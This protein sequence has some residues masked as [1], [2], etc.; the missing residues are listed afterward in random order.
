MARP[1]TTHDPFSAIAEPR[2]RALI[3]VLTGG[4]QTVNQIVETM[5]WNQPMVSKHLGV[6]KRVGLVTERKQ[7]RY[8]AYRLNAAQLKP[9]Q[10]W[11]VEIEK[12]WAN[13]L[14]NLEDYLTTIQSKEAK[15]D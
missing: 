11:V 13:S 8:R 12:Y 5:G 3:E 6:L 14:D 1:R 7:G 10:D 4:E 9:V 15:G 2:R